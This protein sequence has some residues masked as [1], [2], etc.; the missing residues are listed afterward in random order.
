MSFISYGHV[1][2]VIQNTVSPFSVVVRWKTFEQ[3]TQTLFCGWVS[4]LRASYIRSQIRTWE[5]EHTRSTVSAFLSKRTREQSTSLLQLKPI[6]SGKESH[7]KDI[8]TFSDWQDSSVVTKQRAEK[9]P[10]DYPQDFLKVENQRNRVV[11]WLA[12]SAYF[13]HN[14]HE[15]LHRYTTVDEHGSTIAL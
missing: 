7:C 6:K 10:K 9:F 1:F 3:E 2:T 13:R 8:C 12:S 11:D 4:Q 15:A 5:L 14:L